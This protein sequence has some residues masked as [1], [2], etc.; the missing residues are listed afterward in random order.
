[1]RVAHREGFSAG[2]EA[3]LQAEDYLEL[4]AEPHDLPCQRRYSKLKRQIIIIMR[5]M[6][7][8]RRGEGTRPT[9]LGPRKKF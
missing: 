5:C 1:M 8:G 6:R 4:K 2:T 9:L 7:D 3:E